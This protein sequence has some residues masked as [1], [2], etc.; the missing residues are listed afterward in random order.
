MS[1]N[2]KLA[3]A[4]IFAAKKAPYLRAGLMGLVPVERPGLGTMAMDAYGRLYYD[5]AFLEARSL[6]H[7]AFV[8]VHEYVHFHQR[9]AQR[10]KAVVK[11]DPAKLEVWR[12][13]VE[14]PTNEIAASC[15]GGWCPEEATTSAKLGLPCNLTVEEAF[16][17]KW[18]ERCEREEE[19]EEQRQQEQ[20]EENDDAR[21]EVQDEQKRGDQ[22]AEAGQNESQ[23][24]DPGED[25]SNE[26]DADSNDP[27]GDLQRDLQSDGVGETDAG[28]DD[29]QPGEDREPSEVADEQQDGQGETESQEPGENGGTPADRAGQAIGEDNGGSGQG[30]AVQV[31]DPEAL[32]QLAQD[33]GGSACDGIQRPWELGP[34]DDENP[35]LSESDQDM[36]EATIAKAIEAHVA[37]RGEG[38][39]AAALVKQASELLHKPVDPCRELAAMAKYAV[40]TIAGFGEFTYAR[41]SNRQIPGGCLLPSSVKPIPRITLII[42]SSGSMGSDDTALALEVLGSVL[43]HLPDPRGLRVL[44]GGTEVMA[45]KKVFKPEQIQI[46]DG[47]GTDIGSLIRVADQEKP[48]PKV[49]LCVTDGETPWCR[50]DQVQAKVMVCLTRKPRWCS[51]PPA[52]MRTVCLNPADE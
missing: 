25:E 21:E 15:F 32:S 11:S 29:D 10:Q 44:V 26:S 16:A 40:D 5:P 13:T 47:G 33:I 12:G 50:E 7:N 28:G 37:A 19:A 52:W 46:L 31:L 22:N 23:D 45:A 20:Q 14:G 43:K 34:P 27:G 30:D 51:P 36:I 6:K 35:G 24:D 41:P 1:G 49:I 17:I 8:V 2:K 42:D 18:K 48:A 4:R 9:H 39:V 3:E 38:S